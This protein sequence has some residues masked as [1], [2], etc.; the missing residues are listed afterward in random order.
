[1]IISM[2]TFLFERFCV[3]MI[4]SKYIRLELKLGGLDWKNRL[5]SKR[6]KKKNQNALSEILMGLIHV[7]IFKR[8][9]EF[10]MPNLEGKRKGDK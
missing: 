10:C 8:T 1:M 9:W 5:V 7:K 4:M 2:S 6:Q 3:Y